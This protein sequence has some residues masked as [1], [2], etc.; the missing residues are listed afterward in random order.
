MKKYE[1]YDQKNIY[2]NKQSDF[3]DINQIFNNESQ[4]LTIIESPIKKNNLNNQNEY[5]QINK[6]SIQ[7]KKNN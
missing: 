2:S 6:N 1:N 5:L 7:N 3:D 4:E